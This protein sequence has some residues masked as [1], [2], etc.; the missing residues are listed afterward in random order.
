MFS[1]LLAGYLH[2]LSQSV[3]LV[4]SLALE[5]ILK[6]NI[7]DPRPFSRSQICQYMTTLQPDVYLGSSLILADFTKFVFLP[8]YFCT[9]EWSVGVC[10]QWPASIWFLCASWL[11]FLPPVQRRTSSQPTHTLH[12]RAPNHTRRP[13]LNSTIVQHRTIRGSPITWDTCGFTDKWDWSTDCFIVLKLIFHLISQ[14]VER[15][16]ERVCSSVGRRIEKLS[17][18]SHRMSLFK[19]I[20]IIINQ[21]TTVMSSASHSEWE[22]STKWL[23]PLSFLNQ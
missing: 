22:P 3:F 19:L 17:L 12:T 16:R 6:T 14:K 13:T 11:I 1:L 8:R 21:I 20:T 23:G 5:V 9:T 18:S 7:K 15:E 2:G 10:F 4:T